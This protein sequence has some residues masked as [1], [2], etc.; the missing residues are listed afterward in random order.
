MSLVLWGVV[1]LVVLVALHVL[2]CWMESKGWIYYRRTPRHGGST[3]HLL[4]MSSI[5]D[6]RF[7]Q[8]IEIMVEDERREDESGDPP[9][10]NPSDDPTH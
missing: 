6:P 4:Q 7:R 9:G 5:F 1:L 10:S 2:L 8:V 3:Y